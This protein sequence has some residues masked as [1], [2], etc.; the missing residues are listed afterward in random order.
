MKTIITE[1]LPTN[2]KK[3]HFSWKELREGY[4][5]FDG[6]IGKSRDQKG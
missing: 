4:V 2:K 5:L 3:L 6:V 1:C